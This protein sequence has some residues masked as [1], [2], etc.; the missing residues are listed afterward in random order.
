MWKDIQEKDA[1][2]ACAIPKDTCIEL[3]NRYKYLI[4]NKLGGGETLNIESHI[5][6]NA[7][8]LVVNKN[9]PTLFDNPEIFEKNLIDNGASKSDELT[10]LKL[11]L[12]YRIPWEVRKNAKNLSSAIVNSMSLDFSQKSKVKSELSVWVLDTWISVLGLKKIQEKP[13]AAVDTNLDEVINGLANSVQ[14]VAVPSAVPEK[15]AEQVVNQ[16]TVSF[17]KVKGRFGI[18]FG[19]DSAGDVK[20]FNT[21]YEQPTSEESSSMSVTPVKLETAPVKPFK[22]APKRKKDKF[23][24]VKKVPVTGNVGNNK[25]APTVANND[26][27]SSPSF[28]QSEYKPGKMEQQAYDL[29]KKGSTFANQALKIL[30]PI[31][32]GGSVL[33]CRKMGEVYYKGY[34][35]MQN[36]HAAEAWLKLSAEKGD[37]ESLY[38]LGTMYQFGMGVKKDLP[39]AKQFFERAVKLGYAKAADSLKIMNMGFNL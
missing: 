20:V 22:T 13:V 12:M 1:P 15:K 37:A 19:E 39:T 27:T 3:T 26:N 8:Q 11:S 36:Y 18:V 29:L 30:A 17:D 9:D 25:A 14:P 34:G 38:Y 2:T 10:A 4:I 31:A 28:N 33:A 21:W 5:C 16:P 23:E 24:A 32:V 7:L 35:V 6:H